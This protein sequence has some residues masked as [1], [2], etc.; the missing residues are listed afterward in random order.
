MSALL[1]LST[2]LGSVGAV[3]AAPAGD[4]L[5][6]EATVSKRSVQLMMASATRAGDRLVS[7]GERGTILLSDDHGVRW[8]QARVPVSVTLTAVSF[9]TPRRGWAVGHSGVVLATGDGGETWTKQLDGVMAAAIE[10]TAAADEGSPRRLAEADR[11]VRDGADKP[12]LAVHAM[13]EQTVLVVGAYGLAFRTTDGGRTWSSMIGAFDNP[14]GRHLY[15]ILSARGVLHVAAE[16]GGMFRSTDGGHRFDVISMPAKGTFFGVA[17]MSGGDVL[18]AFGLRGT[19]CRS[20]DGGRSWEPVPMP[21]VSFTAETQLG[22]GSF[23]LM[24]ELGS[25]YRSVDNG[26]NFQK[27]PE[28]S[29][30]P[31]ADVAL[32]A[33][34]HLIV[35]GLRGSARLSVGA[36]SAED[37]K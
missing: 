13:D 4:P 1:V 2:V 19:V 30:F 27:L 9:A 33:D 17:A 7:V 18:I 5:E 6:A 12:F 22:D 29:P 23:V 31:P 35:V 11:L 32:A 14:Q 37:G 8:R 10:R 16:Q 24:D 36:A 3:C 34:G 25:S 20:G 15:A 26:K 21:P 28:I